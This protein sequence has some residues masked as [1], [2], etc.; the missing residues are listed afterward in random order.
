MEINP[1]STFVIENSINAGNEEKLISDKNT[2]EKPSESPKGT[3]DKA[4]KE[5]CF[6]FQ[7]ILFDCMLKSMR[8]TVPK[9]D[10]FSGGNAEEIYTSLLDQEYSRIL[11]KNTES[12]LVEALYEELTRKQTTGEIEA[13]GGPGKDNNH[14][15]DEE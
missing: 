6:E 3:K 7:S 8:K 10:L 14:K 4:L 1:F 13:I 2:V 5:K 9:N 15:I 12:S 11:S